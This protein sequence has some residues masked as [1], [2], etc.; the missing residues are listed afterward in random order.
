[1]IK[2]G[3][4]RFWMGIFAQQLEEQRGPCF[5]GIDAVISPSGDVSSCLSILW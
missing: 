1:M 2:V 4:M 5:S 3:A